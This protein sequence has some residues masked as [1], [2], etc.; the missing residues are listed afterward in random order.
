MNKQLSNK[1]IFVYKIAYIIILELFSKNV[2]KKKFLQ[3]ET[4]L[5]V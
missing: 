1:K 5:T 2:N 4:I 3:F